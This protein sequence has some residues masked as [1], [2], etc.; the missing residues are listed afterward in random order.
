MSSVADR[1][2]EEALSLPADLRIGLVEKLLT[3]LNLP[4]QDDIDREWAE[5]IERRVAEVDRGEVTPIPAEE[6]FKSIRRKY[7]L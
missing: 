7:Q 1:I 5:E 6:V 2:T 4:T 3:S